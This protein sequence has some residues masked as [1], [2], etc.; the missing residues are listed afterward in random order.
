MSEIA[1][2][3]V[4]LVDD[5]P[6]M[7]KLLR[8]NLQ[9]SGVHVVT[10]LDAESAL[11]LLGQ[12]KFDIIVVDVVMPAMSG[13]EFTEKARTL[14]CCEGTPILLIT[15]RMQSEDELKARSLGANGILVKPFS[16]SE[17]QAKILE[18]IGG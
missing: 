2:K 9:K 5:D 8:M 13:F 11:Q 6:F 14:A 18:F 4:L 7:V 16:P 17:F 1:G 12:E 3:K 15:A 10:S